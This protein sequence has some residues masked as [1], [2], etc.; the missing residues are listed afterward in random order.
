[1]KKW[2]V[3]LFLL[4]VTNL[5][6]SELTSQQVLDKALSVLG[7]REKLERIH[8]YTASGKVQVAGLSGTYEVSA[9]ASDKYRLS[10]DLGVLKQ[11]RAFDGVHG[12]SKQA[13]ITEQ[14]GAD[15]ARLKRAALF[16]PLLSYYSSGASVRLKGTEAINNMQAYVLEFSPTNSSSEQFY[17]DEKSF[18]PIREVRQVPN[19]Q[20]TTD[21]LII[22][23]S[24]YRPV[25]GILMPFS[26][27]ITQPGQ[28]MSV[29]FD[30]YKINASLDDEL[31][32][33]PSEK[34][35]SE[36]YDVTLSTIPH[37]VY[38][39]NDGVFEPASTDSFYFCVVV[40]EKYNRP[41]EPVA[42]TVEFYSGKNLV[43]TVEF[44]AASLAASRAT[45]LGGF[46]NQEENFD[47]NHY[48][49]QPVK[50]N[51]D[52][53]T[54]R[55]QIQAPKG[56][57]IQK[58][59][60]IPVEAYDQKTKLIFPIKGNFIVAGAHDFNEAHSDEWSQH[61]AY[62]IV[63]LGPNFELKKNGGKTNEDF[64]TWRKE[65]IAPADGVIVFSRND[66]PEN[67]QPGVIDNKVFMS[68]PNPMYAVGGN[69]VVIDHSNGEFSFLAHMQ[70]G[71][72]R[73]KEGD[74]VKQGDVIGLLGNTG[75]SDGPHLHYHL[76]ACATIFRCDGLP[77]HF[78][79]VYEVFSKEK[80]KADFV[81]RGLFLEA[82]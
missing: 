62:D 15:L 6:S 13:S 40:L 82:R 9:K 57:K 32:R 64:Y 44:S 58:Q 30:H 54:Y 1:M 76:M 79:N 33:N 65:V 47:L 27:T 74:R 17:F 49:T 56:P 31:F 11:V 67:T 42:A 37:H 61:Y 43:E 69:N 21:Q 52:R 8:S 51:I 46:A 63:G 25:E 36:P 55:L 28:V 59:I 70:K 77:S 29:Q 38:K 7:G 81:K 71:S 23:Y 16:L 73:V 10:L 18:L 3:F 24:D 34:F 80:L 39:E 12:W 35:A 26:T 53:L 20:G 68:M 5:E 60:G 50:S 72:V 45:S 22:D 41:V 19:R 48:F 4:F 2:L 78:E 66:V 14:Q 75:N